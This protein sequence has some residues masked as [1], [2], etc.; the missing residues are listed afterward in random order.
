MPFWDVVS[1]RLVA[2]K[3]HRRSQ[4][5]TD[6]QVAAGF[7]SVQRFGEW[8]AVKRNE[9]EAFIFDLD[10]TLV[11]SGLDIA[12]AANF[13]RDHCGMPALPLA[14]AQSYVGDGVV[15]LLERTL[16]HDVETGLT[17][18]DGLT[19]SPAQLTTALAVF[20]QRYSE[21]LLDNTVLYD[22][23]TKVL[24]G[25]ND[26]PLHVATNKPRGFTDRMLGEFGLLDIFRRIVG[27]DETP[28]RKPDP[29][30]LATALAGL[31]V[32]PQRVVMVGDSPNDVN[33]AQALGAVSVGCTFGLVPREIVAAS[34]PDYLIDSFADLPALFGD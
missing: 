9:I 16:G 32:D 17:G 8:H 34:G 13:V 27:G 30:H 1:D 23:V 20:K 22:G 31:R 3:Y 15:R 28:A 11:D 14:T 26:V 24:A 2:H 25:L 4:E 29:V 12:L 21:H 19:V 6:S 33:A 10:G 5:G 7:V 18:P